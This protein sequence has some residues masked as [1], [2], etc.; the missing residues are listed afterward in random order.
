MDLTFSYTNIQKIQELFLKLC[1]WHYTQLQSISPK[2]ANETD[3]WIMLMRDSGFMTLDTATEL[4][5]E[6][7]ELISMLVSSIKTSKQSLTPA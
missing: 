3:Y 7:R 6:N 2:E 5:A 4:L 1:C